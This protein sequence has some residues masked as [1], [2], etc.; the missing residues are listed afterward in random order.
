MALSTNSLVTL[1]RDVLVILEGAS[2]FDPL[3]TTTSAGSTS[4]VVDSK[5]VNSDAD[6][7]LMGSPW[8]RIDQTV[9]SGP[10][11]GE[12]SRVKT[13]GLT[14]ATG[15]LAVSPV[16]SATV[17]SATDFSLWWLM[18][19]AVVKR[20]LNAELRLLRRQEFTPVSLLTNTDFE[21]V[22]S[23]AGVDS[24]TYANAV[25][26]TTNGYSSTAGLVRHGVYSARLQGSA[27]IPRIQ[28]ATVPVI[29]GQQFIAAASGL[30]TTGTASLVPYDVTNS[31]NLSGV[32]AVTHSEKQYQSMIANGNSFAIPSGVKQLA[33]RLAGTGA[34][35]DISFDD[36][37]LW[38]CDQAHYELPSWV[39]DPK[40]VVSIG[41]FRRG[42]SRT[43]TNCFGLDEGDF[44]EWPFDKDPMQ[45]EETGAHPYKIQIK[46]P[47]TDPL[48]LLAW[49]PFTELSA[50]SDVTTADRLLI[51]WLTVASC[52]RQLAQTAIAQGDANQAKVWQ[53]KQSEAFAI[54][55]RR[56]RGFR[57]GR[58]DSFT[59][60]APRLAGW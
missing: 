13:S 45:V 5:L 46:T 32:D 51:V 20:L 53:A 19:P 55:N 9:A 7:D 10:A 18:N 38:R 8:L 17:Q 16:F 27:G 30:A 43:D 52:Y 54:A 36:A 6:T 3:R 29:E 60:R 35:D 57:Y 2:S 33:L 15:A 44:I 48:Y 40:D 34:T 56:M 47:V 24:W 31:Q 14:I 41:Y 49:R 50:D 42:I 26:T 39:D 23:G 58:G 11:S 21:S 1:L 59:A 37:V 28:S 4:S 22:T 12:H 25:V